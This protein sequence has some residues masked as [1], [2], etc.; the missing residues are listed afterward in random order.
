MNKRYNHGVVIG[1]FWP[2]HLGHHYLISRAL[3]DCEEVSIF[4]VCNDGY[5]PDVYVRGGWI[6]EALA[7][8]GAGDYT[9][10]YVDD[11]CDDD[12]SEA[13][14]KAVLSTLNYWDIVDAEE[15]EEP[16]YDYTIDA[17]FTSEE[18][19]DPWAKAIAALQQKP[20]AHV[21]VDRAREAVPVSGTLIRQH[22]W[23]YGDYLLPQVR[24][25]YTKKIVLVGAEST[26]TTTL[27]R[28]LAK[29]YGEPYAEEYGRYY[30]Q[31]KQPSGAPWA[32]R[33]LDHI[34]RVHA[35]MEDELRRSAR[36][37]LFCDTDWLAT[38]AFCVAYCGERS[39]YIEQLGK[40]RLPDLYVLTGDEIPL[41]QDGYRDGDEDA[42]HRM[43]DWFR[44]ELAQLPVPCIEVNGDLTRRLM[45][46]KLTLRSLFEKPPFADMTLGHIA[47]SYTHLQ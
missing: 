7:E 3:A 18:Y 30:W 14:A 10:F 42:R 39:S 34:A 27:T 32:I 37:Y 12:N 17:V 2:Y 15:G 31:G 1:K 46:V 16:D 41:E 47:P 35:A 9:I 29:M 8:A 11:I 24:A 6:E 19:G 26:G 40:R 36:R 22:P 21:C 23:L 28:A 4:V 20:C 38:Q 43:T 13:W 45:H 33:E 25:Y 5:D 44:Q